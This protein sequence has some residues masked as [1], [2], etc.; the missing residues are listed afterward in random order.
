MASSLRD[1]SVLNICPPSEEPSRDQLDDREDLPWGAQFEL[2][3]TLLDPDSDSYR[4]SKAT[5]LKKLD[6]KDSLLPHSSLHIL[7]SPPAHEVGVCGANGPKALV[8]LPSPMG[9]LGAC[10]CWPR[11]SVREASRMQVVLKQPS[12]QW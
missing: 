7:L 9:C 2:P 8:R 4:S 6:K 3:P 5:P 1:G 10:Q 11:V 12:Q